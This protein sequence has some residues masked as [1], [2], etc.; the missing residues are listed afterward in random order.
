V[1]RP[2]RA[3]LRSIRRGERPLTEVLAAVSDAEAWLALLRDSPAIAESRTG[4]G[5]TTGCT[6]A[7]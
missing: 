7:T 3:Y 4:A 1:T 5:S 2:D 6:V